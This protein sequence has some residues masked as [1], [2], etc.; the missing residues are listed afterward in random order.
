M[1]EGADNPIEDEQHME[2][3][4]D[5]SDDDSEPD[6][7]K[8]DQLRQ[9]VE[10]I[11]KQIAEN[12]LYYDGH[13]NLIKALQELGELEEARKAREKM[14]EV[15]PLTAELWLEWIRDEQ[16]VCSSEEE[17]QFIRDLFDRAV[18][19]YMNV[20]LWVEYIMFMLGCGDM[21][22]TRMV[23]ERALTAVGTHVAEGTMVWEV[24]LMVEKQIYASLQ[25]PGVVPSDQQLKNQEKQLQKIQKLFKRQ[26]RV[27]LR[28]CNS[29]SVL[30]EASEYFEGGVEK[31]MH[32][33]LKKS[34]NALKEIAPYEDELIEDQGDA[35]KLAVYRKYIARIK[36]TNN[37]AAVQNLYERA[38]ADFCLDPGI[39]EEYVRFVIHQFYGL[40]YVVLPVCERSQRNCPWSGALCEFYITAIQMF[41]VEGEEDST[42][43]KVKGALEKGIGC[44]LQSGSEATRMWMAYLVYLRRQIKWDQPH[45]KQL[46]A[47]REATQQA[48]EFIDKYFGEEGDLESRIPRFWAQI[49]AEYEKSP[50]QAR[51]IWN[52]TI[53]KRNNNFNNANMWLEFIN[54]ERSFGTEK[55]CRK[56]F[57]RALE[58]VWDWVEVIGS[59]YLRFEEET[60]T[61]ETMEEFN[62]RYKDR[63][64]IVNKKRAEDA[65]NEAEEEGKETR[66]GRRLKE[67]PSK[68]EKKKA[69]AES[70]NT[71]AQEVFKSPLPVTKPA[72]RGS[73]DK[74][75]GSNGISEPQQ[76]GKVQ[77]RST[78]KDSTDMP[79]P[80]GL[81]DMPPTPGFKSDVA[82][83]P[84]FKSDVA[85]PPGFKSDVAPPPGFKS[86]VA[87]PP[88]FKTS[89]AEKLHPT[90]RKA[91]PS[92][93]EPEAKSFKAE[94]A[95]G[96]LTKNNPQDDMCTIF[97]SN[98]D[99][100][101]DKD[102]IIPV[103]Q[104]CGDIADFRLVKDFRCRSKG[105][106]YLVFKTREGAVKGL[107]LDRTIVNG[108]PVFVSPYD[109]DNHTHKFRYALNE[110]KNKLFV[111]GLSFDLT[112]DD[113]KKAFEPH[114]KIKDIRLVV[115]RNGHSKG[116]CYIEYDDAETAEKVRQAM[117][118]EELNGKTINVLIS[119]PS[120]KKSLTAVSG[121]RGPSPSPVVL[122]SS[123]PRQGSGMR[124]RGMFS[125]MPRV[126]QRQ[127]PAVSPTNQDQKSPAENQD[128]KSSAENQD[129]KSS[130]ENQDQNKKSN[131]DFRKMFLSK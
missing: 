67:R 2:T 60:G 73:S 105:F 103:F 39:W 15:Y 100:H 122:G 116:T 97:L 113:V 11:S 92:A 50:E 18:K 20:Q 58:R 72:Y 127:K 80:T 124:G 34:Q 6:D 42:A 30:E 74:L 14:S 13:V 81:S 46:D 64:V 101:V 109:P 27:P 128:Q 99:F 120:N 38:V 69:R 29:D 43:D 76:G 49:E 98:L 107:E 16:K 121:G 87:P 84:G 51:A 108:R 117:D 129:Q 130:A 41:A 66:S 57:R 65:I 94:E 31:Y 85:P 47:F 111:R 9:K 17:K 52:D 8:E 79:P 123:R 25:K 106:G 23:G 7:V 71:Q 89:I 3:S 70:S 104:Q 63:M 82:P 56:L 83:P 59:A 110:E 36:E 22:A 126:V 48:V 4:S 61:L 19:D 12:V 53:M 45:D 93:D 119:D 68:K 77:P 90:K 91:H 40:D 78:S 10:E 131:A 24:V 37:P 55:H 28:S 114:G 5:D 21:E 95:H 1:E 125:F 102:E 54:L 32:D 35:E 118:E 26:V 88:G 96:V 62:E 33:D 115:Y 112:E 86:D 75:K 44:G